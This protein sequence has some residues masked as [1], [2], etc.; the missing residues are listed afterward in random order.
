M[1]VV[2]RALAET[3][4]T[5][6]TAT[7][8]GVRSAGG[9][10]LPDKDDQVSF[11]IVRPDFSVTKAFDVPVGTPIKVEVG[12]VVTFTVTVEN[13][14]GTPLTE[15]PLTDTF[16]PTYLRFLR[17]D[18][19]P[20]STASGTLSWTDLTGSGSLAPGSSLT[21]RVTFEALAETSSTT[22]TATVSGV[23]SAGG[24]TLPDK[25]DS[26][27]FSIQAPTAVT[28]ADILAEFDGSGSVILTWVTTAEFDNWGFNVYRAEVD[29]PEQAVRINDTL[30]PGRG[31]SVSGATY[32][33]IDRTVEPGKTYWYWIEDVELTGKTAWHGPVEVYVPDV[34]EPGDGAGHTFLPFIL[35]R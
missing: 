4:Q 10:T 29:D 35:Q 28:M 21:I 34:L 23:R 11:A 33:F 7:V 13:T 22:N 9:Q 26:L 6:N 19:A 30:I 12:D 25:S 31:Q 15:I 5:T 16:D 14:G 8:S 27:A 18:V 24:Q 20:D 2:F 1:K 17:A 32:R 3:A